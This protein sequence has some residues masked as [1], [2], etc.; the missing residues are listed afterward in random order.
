MISEQK[1]QMLEQKQPNFS[2]THIKKQIVRFLSSQPD[3]DRSFIQ[4]IQNNS[5]FC[6]GF[7]ILWLY[8]KWLSNQPKKLDCVAARDDIKWFWDSLSIISLWD[9]NRSLSPN[10][11]ECFDRII[12]FLYF[13]QLANKIFPNFYI[14]RLDLLFSVTSSF[15]FSEE[16]HYTAC[17]TCT[18]LSKFL[19]TVAPENKLTLIRNHNHAIG[20]FKE[21]SDYFLYDSNNKRKSTISKNEDSLSIEIF[22]AFSLKSDKNLCLSIT[23]I[24]TV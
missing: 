16:F 24:G 22:D 8:S 17:F 15:V 2:Q 5:G 7:T 10:E 13:F 9:G 23:I 12:N 20:L 21:Q 6:K 14:H 18:E 4:S 3:R 11:I 19:K 1:H